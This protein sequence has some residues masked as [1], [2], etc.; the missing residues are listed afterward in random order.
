MHEEIDRVAAFYPLGNGAAD[1]TFVF[2][3]PDVGRIAPED[4][5]PLLQKTMAG[6][7]PMSSRVLKEVPASLPVYFNSLTQI[8]MPRWHRGRVALLGDACGC[9]TLLAGQ[10]SHMAMGDAYVL[11]NELQRHAGDHVAAFQAYE[12]LMKPAAE[13]KQNEA[14]RFAKIV[15]PSERS[16][17]WLRRLGTRLMFSRIGLVVG[18]RMF[19]AKS[20]LHGYKGAPAAPPDRP[21][22][23]IAA[24]LLFSSVRSAC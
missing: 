14:E 6:P 3:H 13:R 7:G 15:M 12:A 20:V 10:G 9:L 17:P 22:K 11:A 8:R 23:K 18:M 24:T 19:G 16:R 1:A 2:R 21:R 4:R 5:L